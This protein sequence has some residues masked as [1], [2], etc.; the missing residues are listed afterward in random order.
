MR[1]FIIIFF[2]FLSYSLHSNDTLQ[3]II[4]TIEVEALKP[5]KK[6]VL[7]IF[8]KT[9]INDSLLRRYGFHDAISSLS[10]VPGVY[11]RDY[12]GV[13]GVKTISIRGFSSP[14]TLVMIDGVRINSAQNGT[15]DLNLLPSILLDSYELIRGGSS[16]IFGGNASAGILNFKS[17]D[18]GEK[19]KASISY[20]SFETLE[21]SAKAKF[22]LTPKNSSLFGFSYASSEGN[23][24]FLMNY[25]GQNMTYKRENGNFENLSGIISSTVEVSRSNISF[26]LITSKT[27]RGVPGAVVLNQ[28][29]SKRATL[30]DFFLL[31]SIQLNFTLSTNSVLSLLLNSKLLFENFY[32]PDAIG[33]I[34]KKES[35][36]FNNKY[37]SL[38]V[39]FEFDV[40]EIKFDLY[41][42][43]TSEE[44]GGDFL[45][46]EV[47]GKVKRSILGLCGIMS[48]EFKFFDYDFQIFASYRLDRSNDFK[49]Q[50]SIGVGTKF[51]DFLH[52]F[53]YSTIFSINFRP[54]SF[55]EMYYLNYGT[56]NLKPERCYTINFDFSINH[57]ELLQPKISL[58]Y[59]FTFN[60]II[61]IPKSPLQWSAQN[62]A[63]VESFGL[64]F[65]IN[66][67]LNKLYVL[68]SY[69]HQK[70]VDKTSQSF[71]FR[72]QLPYTPLNIF[73]FSAMYSLPSDFS[74][75]I[76]YFF[77]GERFA[78]PDNSVA[79]RLSPYAIWGINIAKRF[80]YISAK[81]D[82][83][84]EIL[85]I[86][87][88]KYEIYLNYPM[89]GRSFRLSLRNSI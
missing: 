12:S 19:F 25:F 57:I 2:I 10:F 65:S 45:Q 11:I 78:L 1:I 58:F 53:D 27:K 16:S 37:F 5:T 87:D 49:M 38:M 33:L 24:P 75:G 70:T 29:E 39:N 63:K 43:L 82:L 76:N 6:K 77:C 59:Y 83:V 14:N 40:Q 74:I 86:F 44:L 28:Y 88:K 64:E 50:H 52:L 41:T 8:S 47:K 9:N 32:D 36:E 18:F 20:G 71:S 17:Q 79:S 89:P 35:A 46:P 4:K 81:F 42:E 60:K 22:N 68:L 30:D 23:Y 72:K 67:S 7:E 61:S 80:N 31:S 26:L 21:L 48:K 15:F 56:S 34:L 73:S 62:L 54:P 69:T 84:V 13:G 51:I 3:T 55:N 85:N 66:A